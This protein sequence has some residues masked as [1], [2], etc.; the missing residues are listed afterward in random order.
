MRMTV[1]LV[2][3]DTRA[4][5]S[6]ALTHSVSSGSFPDCSPHYSLLGTGQRLAC[7]GSPFHWGQS[8]HSQSPGS[9]PA[10]LFSGDVIWAS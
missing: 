1:S 7:P 3:Q 8:R 2:P 5:A 10:A 9:V 4:W 6:G